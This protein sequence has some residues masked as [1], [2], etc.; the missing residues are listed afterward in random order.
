MRLSETF[1]A[2]GHPNIRSSHKTTVM[3][4]KETKLSTRGDCVVAVRS[5]K[6]LIDLD[7]QLINAMRDCEAKIRLSIEAGELAFEVAGYG[8]P[9]LTMSHTSDIVARK[10]QYICDRTIMIKADK[11]ACDIDD[12]LVDRLK[13]PNQ[14]VC[15]KIT[16]DL[17]H[18]N[19]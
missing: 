16:V 7:D 15:I 18:K 1:K 6:G 14:M 5:E 8:D 11:A 19:V 17:C 3:V 2:W 10:S 12:N 13:D 4:T 9:N